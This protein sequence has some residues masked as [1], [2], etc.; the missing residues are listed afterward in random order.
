M[1]QIDLMYCKTDDF[2]LGDRCGATVSH[3]GEPSAAVEDV[4]RIGRE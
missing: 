3:S 1:Y 4:G 2:S